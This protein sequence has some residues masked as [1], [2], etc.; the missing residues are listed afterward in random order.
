MEAHGHRV[1]CKVGALL[2]LGLRPRRR[3]QA[4]SLHNTLLPPPLQKIARESD[5]WVILML[6]QDDT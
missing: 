3:Q 2:L 1:L 5:T 6:Y 4:L